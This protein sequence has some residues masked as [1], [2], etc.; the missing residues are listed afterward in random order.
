MY[1]REARIFTAL[2]ISVAI[3]A[4][5]LLALGKNPPSAG[6]FCLED[7]YRLEPVEKSVPSTIPQISNRWNSIRIFYKKITKPD[8]AFIKDISRI[9]P[10]DLQCHFYICKG[11]YGANGQI[12]STEQW[13]E[14]LSIKSRSISGNEGL[15]I[16]SDEKT[17]YICL[18][19]DNG[20]R[21]PS[22]YQAKRLEAL[23]GM[24][25]KNFEIRPGSVRFPGLGPIA[26]R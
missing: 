26:G 24:L 6:A 5:V 20:K 19:T 18:L 7:Y 16:H 12:V 21:Y 1:S 13:N 22:D 10:Y 8:K 23:V 3:C 9:R 4:T 11:Y 15:R 14:Q 17:I 2:F 25:C